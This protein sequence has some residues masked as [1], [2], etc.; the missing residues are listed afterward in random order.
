MDRLIRRY[1]DRWNINLEAEMPKFAERAARSDLR[2]WIY[3]FYEGGSKDLSLECWRELI[4]RKV[5]GNIRLQAR[6]LL[7]SEH[8][9]WIRTHLCRHKCPVLDAVYGNCLKRAFKKMLEKLGSS[10]MKKTWEASVNV[11]L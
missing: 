8:L 11:F 3:E 4:E 5:R 7:H 2:Y 10:K 6:G 1:A 9:F